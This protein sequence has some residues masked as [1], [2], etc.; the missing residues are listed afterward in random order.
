MSRTLFR[1]TAT[2]AVMVTV[3]TAAGGVAAA[4][5]TAA[6]GGAGAVPTRSLVTPEVSATR[7]TTSP[8]SAVDVAWTAPGQISGTTYAVVRSSAGGGEVTL[9]CTSSPC[10]DT[11][12]ASGTTYTYR[13][14]AALGTRWTATGQATA[15]T[16][17]AAPSKVDST[18]TL[19]S[20]Q[21]PA[22]TG[23]SVTLTATIAP[24]SPTPTGTV[25]FS[26]GGSAIAGCASQP[27]SAATR[28]ATCATSWATLGARSV[29][30]TYSGDTNYLTSSASLTQ[31]VVNGSVTGLGFTNVRLLND[32]NQV[33]NANPTVTCTGTI[34]TAGYTCT[35]SG[36][37]R[38]D[39]LLADVVFLTASGNPAVYAGDAATTL[40]W[41]SS[42]GKDCPCSG[43][44]TVA[45]NATTSTGTLRVQRSGNNS[46]DATVT[47]NDGANTYSAK[48][49]IS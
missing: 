36:T 2:A 23:Q 20:S 15:S 35:V 27:V 24:A 12:L 28:Q 9:S 48:L 45:A 19:T 43:S 26:A 5:W 7:S 46:A 33:V 21:N 38:N 25:Q 11:G 29:S 10:S 13:V 3:L 47:L 4:A 14:T 30:A 18:T 39:L 37:S 42:N 8:S 16:A 31:R 17:A 41:S 22:T 6:G 34:G 40:P 49:V 1:S 44:V 32:K